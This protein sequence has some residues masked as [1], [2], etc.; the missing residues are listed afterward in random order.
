MIIV[1][2]FFNRF[3]LVFFFFFFQYQFEALTTGNDRNQK[4]IQ[5]LAIRLAIYDKPLIKW[6]R[7]WWWWPFR[8]NPLDLLGF[9]ECFPNGFATYEPIIINA[10]YCYFK[11]IPIQPGPLYKVEKIS[12]FSNPV[13]RKER[14]L[15]C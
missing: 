9:G 2:F 3:G 8:A 5:F 12:Q 7:W 10:C 14:G 6:A 15:F 13:Q 4:A 11:T 1:F